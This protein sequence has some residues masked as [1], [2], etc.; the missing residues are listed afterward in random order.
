MGN[1]LTAEKV[2]QIDLIDP[3]PFEPEESKPADEIDVVDEEDISS[4][5]ESDN[6]K[7]RSFD[8]EQPTLF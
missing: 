4:R 2:N 1:Q 6:N 3:I 7:T 8:D 5:S